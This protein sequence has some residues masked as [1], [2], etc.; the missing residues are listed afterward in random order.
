MKTPV[1]AFIVIFFLGMAALQLFNIYWQEKKFK[2]MTETQ[3]TQLNKHLETNQFLLSTLDWSTI[4]QKK[5]LFMRDEIIDQWKNCEIKINYEKAYKIAETNIVE[6]EKYLYI[7][8]MFILAIQW[9]ESR[10]IDSAI[11]DK[12]AM[13]VMQIMPSTARLLC[14]FFNISYVFHAKSQLINFQL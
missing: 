12:G 10:F 5:I 2:T 3:I 8:P 13:G 14:G 1:K 11:S 6:C 7:D 4:R 9:Q